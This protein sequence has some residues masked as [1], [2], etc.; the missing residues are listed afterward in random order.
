MIKIFAL[1]C[2]CYSSHT[3]EVLLIFLNWL[4]TL[5][6]RPWILT[7][8]TRSGSSPAPSAEWPSSLPSPSS[9]WSW[10]LPGERTRREF[11]IIEWNV[12][13]WNPRWKDSR[14]TALRLAVSK[15]GPSRR[16]GLANPQVR[17]RREL[18][19]RKSV[20]LYQMYSNLGLIS[21]ALIIVSHQSLII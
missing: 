16:R 4:T 1:L 7:Y 5:T 6:R 10:K 9:S 21:L 8:K 17:A 11:W 3:V 18:V 2:I 15:M 13:V 12:S 20:K 19:R 14:D